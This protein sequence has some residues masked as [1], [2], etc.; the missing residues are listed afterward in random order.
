MARVERG[1]SQSGDPKTV[2]KGYIVSLAVL[3]NW[4]RQGIGS[5]L[6]KEALKAM[7]AWRVFE[8]FLKVRV[9][10]APAINLYRKSGFEVIETI[11]QYYPN[12]EDAYVMSVRLN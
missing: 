7:S 5:V 1:L 10:N 2:R 9:S 11:H 8:C 3:P 4:R 12:G 6:M